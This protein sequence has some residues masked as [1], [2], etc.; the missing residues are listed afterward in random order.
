MA[1]VQIIS[2]PLLDDVSRLA[3]TSPRQRKNYNFH[4]RDES[5]CHRLLNAL[6][7]ATYIS[8]HCHRDD[9]KGESIVILRGKVGV[10]IFT[11]DGK[12]E[13]RFVIEPNSETLGVD[14]PSGVIHGLVA[15]E[16]N[17]V[18]FE[19]K[20]GPYVPLAENERVNWAPT[21]GADAARDYLAWM[22]S[23]FA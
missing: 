7:P 2:K 10:L 21:E 14:I 20:A 1:D 22:K 19:A 15:L 17:S 23:Q 11:G 12:I 18:F 3:Q 4:Q 8:P 16:K 9:A 6:E 13:Q 5:V